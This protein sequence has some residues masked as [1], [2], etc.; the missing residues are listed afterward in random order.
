MRLFLLLPLAM[1]AISLMGQTVTPETKSLMDS[2][3]KMLVVTNAGWNEVNGEMTRYERRGK[4]WKKVGEAIGIV[5]GKNGMAWDDHF[6]GRSTDAADPVKREGDGRSPAGVFRISHT[7]GFAPKI[8]SNDFYLPPTPTTECVD[9]VD[10]KYYNE[11]VD[12]LKVKDVD[13]NSSEKMR[14]VEG[15]RYGA[16]VAYNDPPK[17]GR[18]SCIFLHVWSR[19]GQGT[20]GCTAMAESDAQGLLRWLDDQTILVQMPKAE[21]ERL[22]SAF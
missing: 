17:R 7:F 1:V 15:Y 4:S 6:S 14:Q 5:V 11:I 13:W 19:A 8:G 16:V 3:H 12:R 2:A 22:G 10:S 20:A 18:G 21:Y 9:D